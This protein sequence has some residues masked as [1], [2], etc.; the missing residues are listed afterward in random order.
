MIIRGTFLNFFVVENTGSTELNGN[1]RNADNTKDCR[2]FPVF[3]STP[4]V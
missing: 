4:G 2:A 3:Q 1:R